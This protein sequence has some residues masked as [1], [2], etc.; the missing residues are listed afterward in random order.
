VNRSTNSSA[1]AGRSVIATRTVAPAGVASTSRDRRG[2]TR[3]E[4]RT[5]SLS[6]SWVAPELGKVTFGM[7]VDEWWATTVH[8]RRQAAVVCAIDCHSVNRPLISVLHLLAGTGGSVATTENIT[9]SSPPI[10]RV[11]LNSPLH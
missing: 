11:R 4:V 1:D 8:L 9:C 3:R 5:K 10:W 6:G 7:W 2:I